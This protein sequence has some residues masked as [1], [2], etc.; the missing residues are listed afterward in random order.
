MNK[1]LNNSGFAIAGIL[2][3]L[4]VIFLALIFS[5]LL[6]LNNRK[7]IL[8]QIKKDVYNDLSGIISE[9]V[10]VDL[11]DLPNVMV[12]GT[13]YSLPSHFVNTLKTDDN[14]VCKIDDEIVT[15][16]SALQTGYYIVNCQIS[17]GDEVDSV[18]KELY[19]IAKGQPVYYNP[20]E[21][22]KCTDYIE[23]NSA[24]ENK[25]GCMKWYI[26]ADNSKN[27]FNMI[28]DHNTTVNVAWNKE[29]DYGTNVA[30]ENSN[31]KPLVD[32]LVTESKWKSTPRLITAEEVNQITGKTEWTNTS[33]WYCLESKTKDVEVYPY[34][35]NT[36]KLGW[37]YD[38]T[39]CNEGTTDWK[40]PNN[41]TTTAGYWTSTTYGTPGSGSRVWRV[42]RSGSLDTGFAY[43]TNFAF[44]PVITVSKSLFY[45]IKSDDEYE[46]NANNL[47]TKLKSIV[48]KSTQEGVYFFDS[49]GNLDY[50]SNDIKIILNQG[51]LKPKGN[52]SIHNGTVIYACFNYGTHNYE[53]D[54]KTK[55]LSERTLPC[56]TDRY[57]NLVI[58]GDL[59]YGDNTNFENVGTYQDGY[60]SYTSSTSSELVMTDYIPVDSNKTYELGMDLKASN[61]TATYYVGFREY[62][63]DKKL[64]YAST[65]MYISNTLTT[66]SENLN[67][68]DTVVHLTD[69]TNWDVAT[70]TMYW[71]RGFIFWNYKDSTGYE[72]PELTY[73]QNVKYNYNLYQDANV[74][75]EN[76]TITLSSA[77]TGGTYKAGTQVSQSTSGMQFNYSILVN[78]TLTADWVT[79]KATKNVTGIIS[80]GNVSEFNHFRPG[81]KYVRMAIWADYNSTAD[82][83][84]YIRNVYF[85]EVES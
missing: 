61:T 17:A 3:T 78:K 40:C 84:T 56:L 13:N 7:T 26:Y 73:S 37:L 58:N 14:V 8:D 24:T 36:G 2:Y 48:T 68:G 44:R 25:T 29:G 12:E 32:A 85:K 74:D 21:G 30:Y 19:V 27:T 55:K 5:F 54:L 47:L 31:I 82:T 42:H 15:D 70:S 62:D 38:H 75:K 67:N 43:Y 6:M 4:L 23:A 77:W 79:Y 18:E 72:Y 59:A 60:I 66:L 50:G 69:L 51:V 64:I 11:N 20:V 52:V 65:V 33:T 76:N 28:L 45:N 49:L 53:Y 57:S 16:T 81:T 46:T 10:S 9:E 22:T 80:S 71:R 41:D 1:K 35:N 39:Y 34:C 83:T 63:S